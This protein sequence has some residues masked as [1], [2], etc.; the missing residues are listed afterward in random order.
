MLAMQPARW[1][2]AATLCLMTGAPVL[3]QEIARAP[4][5]S[6]WIADMIAILLLVCVA[7]VSFMSSKRGHRD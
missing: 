7:V 6:G 2:L 5:K 3:A 1:L 4:E